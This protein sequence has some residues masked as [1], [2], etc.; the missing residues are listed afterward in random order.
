MTLGCIAAD[1]RAAAGEEFTNDD[2]MLCYF[3]SDGD[4]MMEDLRSLRGNEWFGMALKLQD[5]RRTDWYFVE[6]RPHCEAR[7]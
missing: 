3:D 2:N 7:S 4:L 5:M 6:D 1:P